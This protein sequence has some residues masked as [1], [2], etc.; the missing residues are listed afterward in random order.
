MGERPRL[1]PQ[2]QGA[3]NSLLGEQRRAFPHVVVGS[4]RGSRGRSARVIWMSSGGMYTRPLSVSYL[5][6][7]SDGVERGT[8]GVYDG[9]KAYAYTKRAQVE[10]AYHLNQLGHGGGK[11]THHSV[12]P[13]WVDTPGI[14]SSLPKFWRW[15]QGR[16][17]SL[18]QGADSAVWLTLSPDE[19]PSGFWFD[20]AA[21]SPYLL[22]HRPSD[23]Q[24]EELLSFIL[25][26]LKLDSGWVCA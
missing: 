16:L 4:G 18:A 19:L 8:T 25:D 11:V 15:T 17:R 13:G 24:R 6:Q 23:E 12:H 5:R 9:V 14:R 10:L 22:G 2:L 21:R 3:P 20:R 26:E 1:A 7:L